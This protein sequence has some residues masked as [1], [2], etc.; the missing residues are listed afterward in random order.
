MRL[1]LYIL[2]LLS[3]GMALVLLCH[4]GCIWAFGEF[5]IT[6]PDTVVLSIETAMIVGIMLFSLL[7]LFEQLRGIRASGNPVEEPAP[8]RHRQSR[9]LPYYRPPPGSPNPPQ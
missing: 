3:F 5:V 2:S 4:F 8:Q 6:E 9:P 7:C 1:K